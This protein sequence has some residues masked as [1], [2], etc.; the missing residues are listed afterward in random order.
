MHR[1]CIARERMTAIRSGTRGGGRDGGGWPA[2]GGEAGGGRG[3]GEGVG[4]R[5]GAALRKGCRD[6]RFVRHRLP[7][8]RGVVVLVRARVLRSKKYAHWH[9]S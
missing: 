9:V 3:R 5:V 6:V 4:T 8:H 7:D 2:T 1:R